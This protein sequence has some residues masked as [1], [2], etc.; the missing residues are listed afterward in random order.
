MRH[1]CGF[2]GAKHFLCEKTV[3][4]MAQPVFSSCC[5]YKGK[6]QLPTISR[7]PPYW[8]L[9]MAGLYLPAPFFQGRLYVAETRVGTKRALR[10]VVKCNKDKDREGTCQN[11]CSPGAA[12]AV[13]HVNHDQ[14]VWKL[15]TQSFSGRRC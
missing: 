14:S 13:M 8:T 7:Y 9:R 15:S 3:G 4:T 6:I 12:V 11:C 5:Y 1:I 10:V 2:C